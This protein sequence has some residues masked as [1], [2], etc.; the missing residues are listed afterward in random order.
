MTKA[1]S[2]SMST[3]LRT[4]IC[5]GCERVDISIH[6]KGLCKRCYNRKVRGEPL[7]KFEIDVYADCRT[8]TDKTEIEKR[9]MIYQQRATEA[10]KMLKKGIKPPSIFVGFERDNPG[11]M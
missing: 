10:M 3:R 5:W 7:V 6:A 2:A 9:I 11:A 4:T 8:D 1:P